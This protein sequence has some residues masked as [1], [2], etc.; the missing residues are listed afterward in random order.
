MVLDQGTMTQLMILVKLFDQVD[1]PANIAKSIGITIQ[2]VNYHLKILKKK[3]F[4]NEKNEIS[5]E[6]FSFLESGL[7]SLRDFVSENMTKI[8]DIMTWEAVADREIGKGEKVSIYMEGGYMHAGDP[9]K[10]GTTGVSRNS[11]KRYEVVAVT[12]ISGIIGVELGSILI[13][14]LP[15]IEEVENRPAFLEAVKENLSENRLNAVV[16]EEA[17]CSLRNLDVKPD[18]E[19]A[20]LG[21]VFEAATRGQDSTL[22]ISS[23]RFHYLLSE[24]KELQNKF[25]EISVRIKYL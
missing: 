8:D 21:G 13:C 23:R 10:T 11:A 14:V 4:V 6:G 3:G 16:G 20:S 22:F 24:L 9:E 18:M 1:K 17:F 7:T 25:K 15:P 2:G 5:K 12:S 19:Y